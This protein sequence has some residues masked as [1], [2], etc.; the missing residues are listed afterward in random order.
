MSETKWMQLV[1]V[2]FDPNYVEIYRAPRFRCEVGDTVLVSNPSKYGVVVFEDTVS[3][4]GANDIERIKNIAKVNRAEWPLPVVQ[5]VCKEHDLVF[6]DSD[7]QEG[8][9]DTV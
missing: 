9:D 8:D 6:G 4:N 1:M 2:R 3:I 5:K 7:W